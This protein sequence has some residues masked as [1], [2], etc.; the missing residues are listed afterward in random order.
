MRSDVI[1]EVFKEIKLSWDV[2]SCGKFG[3]SAPIF[4]IK[5]SEKAGLLGSKGGD[6]TPPQHFSITIYQWT[7]CN[8]K[9]ILN[10]QTCNIFD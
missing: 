5:H 1:N 10:F 3:G 6:I 2:E 9:E 4:R 7:R 8:I